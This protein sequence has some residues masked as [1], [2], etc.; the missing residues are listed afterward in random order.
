MKDLGDFDYI[1]VGA[2]SAGSVLAN[3]LS[4]D[5]SKT[6][7]LLEAG[8]RD[9]YHWIHIPVGYLYCIG[10]P[11]TDWCYHTQ[12]EAGLNGRAIGYPRGRVLGGCSSINGMLYLRG[13]ARDYDIWRQMGNNGWGWD[14]VLPYFK[15]SEDHFAGADDM[16]GAGGEWKVR[17]P[18]LSWEILDAFSNAAQAVGIPKSDDFNRG[19]NEGVGYFQVNQ[20]NGWRWSTAKGFLRPAKS[21]PNLRIEVHAQVDRL[22]L[23]GK[24]VTGVEFTQDGTQVAARSRGEVILSAGAINSPQIMMLSG[25]GPA[26]HLADHGID[27]A[28]NLP[29][30]GQNLQDHLQLR[31][32]Y[33]VTGVKTLNRMAATWWGQAKIG[34]EYALKRSGPMSMAPSQLG[35]FAKSDPSVATADLEFHVQP[36]S[37]PKF[38]EDLDPFPAFTASVCPLR[39]ESRGEIRLRSATPTDKPVIAPNYLSTEADRLTAARAIRLTRNIVAQSPLAKYRPEELRPGPG[40]DD[41]DAALANAA[42]DIGTTIFHPVG[43]AKMGSDPMAVVDDQLRVRGIVGLRVVDASVMPNITSGNTNSPVIMIAEKAADMMKA[44]QG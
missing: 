14:D 28:H 9:T 22:V 44:G 38:G 39:P 24:R 30:V 15:K 33:K 11:R 17:K 40:F 13:Q 20:N 41:S 43:T 2:G 8:G 27:V 34:L 1:I 25:I 42:G 21:R 36:L 3:R 35:A 29:G 18:R 37:L 5:T 10:N 4:E 31:C 12:E 7:L 6:V 16:H 26:A 23:D 19:D 32:A